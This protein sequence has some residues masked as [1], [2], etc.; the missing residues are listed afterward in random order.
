MA[1]NARIARNYRRYRGR[2]WSV[3]RKVRRILAGLRDLYWDAAHP[4]N[5][6]RRDINLRRR[7]LFYDLECG[8][9]CLDHTYLDGRLNC[10]ICGT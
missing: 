5:C 10:P 1:P 4:S 6:L 2:E 7:S 8:D 9:D 3:P